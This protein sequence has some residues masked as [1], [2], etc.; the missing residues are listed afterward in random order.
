MAETLFVPARK[1][2]SNIT[3]A[4][5]AV[6]TTTVPH[7]YVTGEYVRIHMPLTS[8]MVQIAQQYAPI[9]VIDDTNF[10][11]D[12]DTRTYAPFVTP[13]PTPGIPYF[14]SPQCI[15]IGSVNDTLRGAVHNSLN[16]F[17]T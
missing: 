2:I 8:G 9:E 3:N 5:R 1:V 13:T 16:P 4:P 11:I 15:A 17:Y 12:I 10:Y 14:Q 7:D 6:I